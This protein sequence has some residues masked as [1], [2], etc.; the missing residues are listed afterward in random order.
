MKCSSMQDVQNLENSMLHYFIFIFWLSKTCSDKIRYSKDFE[1]EMVGYKYG[2]E[3]NCQQNE[4]FNPT[5]LAKII[6]TLFGKR[7]R[8]K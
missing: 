3:I 1:G 8:R 7:P 2:G 6:P 4:V 5:S